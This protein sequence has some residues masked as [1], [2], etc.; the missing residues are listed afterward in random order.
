M[1][2]YLGTYFLS[3]FLEA[4]FTTFITISASRGDIGLMCYAFALFCCGFIIPV[5]SGACLGWASSRP[6]RTRFA[7]PQRWNGVLF[8]FKY[9]AMTFITV[10][11]CILSVT[12]FQLRFASEGRGGSPNSPPY[13]DVRPAAGMTFVCVGLVALTVVIAL[14]S[15]FLVN[16][17]KRVVD[18]ILSRRESGPG[19]NDYVQV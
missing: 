7:T 5:V 19:L 4:S 9:T 17:W 13:I 2:L 11:I 16:G 15:H 3:L 10:A 12:I 14:I 6:P 8:F 1:A 18:A